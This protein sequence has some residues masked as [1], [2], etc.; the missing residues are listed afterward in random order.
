MFIL[1][2]KMKIQ[3]L[4][5]IFIGL[6]YAQ[7]VLLKF[8]T[9]CKQACVQALKSSSSSLLSLLRTFSSIVLKHFPQ[10]QDQK[11]DS[12]K[13]MFEGQNKEC[14]K[15]LQCLPFVVC[16]SVGSKNEG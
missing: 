14:V 16:L 10:R 13:E 3:A 9:F 1:H 2:Y 4:Y 8:Q 15:V 12:Q 7:Q 11:Y 6:T 5:T